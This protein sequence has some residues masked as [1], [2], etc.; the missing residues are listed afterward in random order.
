MPRIDRL[1]ICNLRMKT[2]EKQVDA[3]TPL[4]ERIDEFD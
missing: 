3:N 4:L 1:A 2:P